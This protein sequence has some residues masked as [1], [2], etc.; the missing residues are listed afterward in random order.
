MLTPPIPRKAS[1]PTAWIA[2]PD[3]D[4]RP[5][6][7]D[8]DDSVRHEI[9]IKSASA[10]TLASRVSIERGSLQNFRLYLMSVPNENQPLEVE[11]LS[12]LKMR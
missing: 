8:P 7:V 3:K 6:T 4:P 12:V 9:D 10:A 11:F 1:S 2:F 5:T